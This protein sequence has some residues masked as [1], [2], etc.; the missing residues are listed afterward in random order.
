MGWKD[1]R[2]LWQKNVSVLCI[3]SRNTMSPNIIFIPSVAAYLS[4]SILQPSFLAF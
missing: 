1:D 2:Y 4:F 3:A